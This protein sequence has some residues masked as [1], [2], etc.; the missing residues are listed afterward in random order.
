MHSIINWLKK[1]WA[2]LVAGLGALAT[3]AIAI[4]G[5]RRSFPEEFIESAI[6]DTLKDI[7]V[8]GP[9]NINDKPLDNYKKEKHHQKDIADVVDEINKRYR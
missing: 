9:I 8:P 7:E 1:Y 3:L 5:R 6:N 4:L 2:L